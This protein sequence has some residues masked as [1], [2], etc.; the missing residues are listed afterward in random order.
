MVHLT[1]QYSPDIKINTL[2]TS[3]EVTRLVFVFALYSSL[4]TFNNDIFV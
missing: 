4:D 2:N 3:F 1:H